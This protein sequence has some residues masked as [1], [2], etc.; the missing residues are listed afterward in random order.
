MNDSSSAP[1]AAVSTNVV[2]RV[3]I[4][5]LRLNEVTKTLIDAA[6]RSAVLR[7]LAI[8]DVAGERQIGR[9]EDD[10][11]IRS[12]SN[13]LGHQILGLVATLK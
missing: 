10:P 11:T 5:G 13:S 6:V 7:E 2:L 12:I 9:P 1:A 3:V 8:L 4:R